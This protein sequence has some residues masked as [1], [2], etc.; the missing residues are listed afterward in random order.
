MIGDIHSRALF[1]IVVLTSV[2]LLATASS[3]A[4]QRTMK[5]QHAVGAEVSADVPNLGDLG[6]CLNYSQ[7]LLNSYWQVYASAG[8]NHIQ[9]DRGPLMEYVDCFIGGDFMY[10]LIATRSRSVSLYAGGGAFIGYEFYD[11]RKDLPAN[12]NT[13]LPTGSFL[14]GISPR[15]EAEFFLTR[16]MAITLGTSAMVNFSSPLVKLRPQLRIGLRIDI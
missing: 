1:L 12:I 14:Y 11:P 5:G 2:L 3:A 13:N 7:Y 15:I 8:D 6:L 9:T 16:Q 10:R 4:A